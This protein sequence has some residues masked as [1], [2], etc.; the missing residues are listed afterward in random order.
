M[1]LLGYYTKQP[2]EVETY[3]IRFDKDMSPTDEIESTY[4]LFS[5]EF[6]NPWNQEIK[7]TVYTPVLADAGKIIV[8]TSDIEL[9]TGITDGFRLN[10]ANA[11]QTSGITVGSI[12]V[13]ARG[14]TI[15]VL[16]NGVFIEEAKTES[17]LV[18]ATEDQR[19]RTRVFKGDP[20]QTY[21]VQVT[22]S[23]SEG[24]TMQDEFIIEIE[25]D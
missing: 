12:A 21:K 14:T 20:F 25:E 17:V 10:V 5:R 4:T 6:D 11:S 1:S 3:G 15:A 18:K 23:T 8:T 16:S 22:V 19:V 24:R 7:S 13:P 2:V 9:P